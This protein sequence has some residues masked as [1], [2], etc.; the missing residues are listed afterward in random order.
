MTKPPIEV[1]RSFEILSSLSSEELDFLYKQMNNEKFV[2]GESLF[3]EGDAG[4][5]MYIV[6]SGSVSISVNTPDGKILEIAEI[7]E[8]N[9]FG[10]MSMF[11]RAVRSATCSTKC[12][13]S[14]L[15]L[16]ADDFYNFIKDHPEAGIN[17]MYSMLK[18]TTQRLLT[19]GAFLSDMVIWGEQARTRAITDDFTGLYNRRFL[20]EA[21]EDRFA[22]AKSKGRP[23]SLVMIDLDNFGTINNECG[24]EM[25]DR[26]ILAVIPIFRRL[27]NKNDILARYGG[28]EFTFLLP[29]STG[30]E[31]NLICN[32]LVHDIRDI[33]LLKKTKGSI[34]NITAS[35]GISSFPENADTISILSERADQALY[36]AKDAGRD[37]AVLWIGKSK[38]NIGKTR[39]S[40]IKLRNQIISNIFEGIVSRDCF[41]VM[42][43]QNPDEDCVSSMIAMGLFLNKFS[44]TV[45]LLFPEKIN[46]NYQ[47][48]LNICKYNAIDILQTGENLPCDISTVIF[49]DTPKPV[50]REIFPDSKNVYSNNNILKIEIDHHLGA[51]SEYIGDPGYCFVDEASSA[52]EL[53]G[54]L[55]FKLKNRLDLIESYNIQDLFSRNFVLAV[56]TG[57]IGDSK[58]GKYLKTRRERW[59]YHLFSNMFNEMLTNKTRKDSNNFSTMKE[60]FTELQQMSLK[61]E[62]CFT[63][64]MKEK[65]DISPTIG[66]VVVSQDIIK[67]MR[68]VFDHDTIVSVARY[69]ADSLAEYSKILSLVAYYDDN[70]D[71]DLIQFR[72]RRSHSY[73]LLD[74]RIILEAYDISNGG[75]HPGAIGF[76]IPSAK[77]PDLYKYVEYL[78]KGIEQMILE[79]G[80]SK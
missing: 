58:M 2:T 40:S 72:V 16:K 33:N 18:I 38:K 19:T 34:K 14:V 29:G 10:E 70:Q 24:Q 15:S 65:V 78:V 36:A 6:L 45:Y 51:D 73:N 69:A 4:D 1:L 46:E 54:L 50:M 17:I 55:A 44:K 64:M 56:L 7:S 52:S 9:F 5:I 53:V 71:S 8:G 12:D 60:V 41:L 62:E 48:L 35:I 57:I 3:K 77:I 61:E 31:A 80:F 11:D 25:G 76:R 49:M 42:G 13:T 32:T 27:F 68:T 75:G 30:V 67:Q 66:S 74:L 23:L 20:D 26:I 43:H 37:R 63:L 47:Y 28:D 39:I 22:E 59:F 21:L 79:K